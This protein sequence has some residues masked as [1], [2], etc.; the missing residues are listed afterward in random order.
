MLRPDRG[1]LVT[2]SLGTGG[3]PTVDADRFQRGNSSVPRHLVPSRGAQRGDRFPTW[4]R[5]LARLEM[6]A[7]KALGMSILVQDE[8]LIGRH[9]EGAGRLA[10]DEEISRSH[11]RVTVDADGFC[12]I[13][14]L[15]ST[16]GTFVN[17]V[18]ITGRHLLSENDRIELGGTTLVVRELPQRVT[19]EVSAPEAQ[20][21]V[22]SAV[23]SSPWA[24]ITP[25]VESP[26]R[27]EITPPATL[28]AGSS[29]AH[30]AP[31][32]A[33]LPESTSTRPRARG[34]D[35]NP[36]RRRPSS[37]FEWRSTSPPAKPELRS[38][39]LPSRFG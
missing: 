14:D 21:T 22:F 26:P 37:R 28:A 18:C 12:T 33:A 13:E 5:R 30:E 8:L 35:S 3:Q 38:T 36:V 6:I 1:P 7:G 2:R 39:T 19:E 29:A 15:G 23:E 31:F 16:N 4:I 27:A 34:F 10:E 9:A 20:G 32:E 11:A 17:G 24:E 25:A